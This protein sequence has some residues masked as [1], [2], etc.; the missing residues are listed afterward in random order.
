M[1]SQE[2]VEADVH[3]K[4]IDLLMK[5][6]PH[7]TDSDLHQA[8]ADVC[9]SSGNSTETKYLKLERNFLEYTLYALQKLQTFLFLSY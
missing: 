5:T 1:L 2:N 6:L 3:E 4:L 9:F 8:V 7:I